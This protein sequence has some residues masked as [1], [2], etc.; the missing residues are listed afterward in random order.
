MVGGGEE[1]QDI[2]E[3]VA[4][5]YECIQKLQNI[6][7]TASLSLGLLSRIVGCPVPNSE[8]MLLALSVVSYFK[9]LEWSAC[10]VARTALCISTINRTFYLI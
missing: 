2:F 5:F 6:I 9:L 10:K 3:K 4:L 7:I 1:L 8:V